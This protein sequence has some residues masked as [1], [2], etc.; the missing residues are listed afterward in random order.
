MIDGQNF[1]LRCGARVR[2]QGRY[3]KLGRPATSSSNQLATARLGHPASLPHAVIDG[4]SSWPTMQREGEGAGLLPQAGPPCHLAFGTGS[5]RAGL[6]RPVPCL[7]LAHAPANGHRL[8]R[9]GV[10]AFAR[11]MA[12]LQAESPCGLNAYVMHAQVFLLDKT[13]ALVRACWT[14]LPARPPALR[15]TKSKACSITNRGNLGEATLASPAPK[16]W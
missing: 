15:L 5:P 7:H 16:E 13:N 9:A 11:P 12:W 14:R 10:W 6:V 3:L 8:L 2:E 4:Q 1:G